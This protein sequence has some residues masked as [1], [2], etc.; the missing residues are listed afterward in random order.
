MSTTNPAFSFIIKPALKWHLNLS[1]KRRHSPVYKMLANQNTSKNFIAS[2]V[3][4]FASIYRTNRASHRAAVNLFV[5]LASIRSWG[6][7]H[8]CR[9]TGCCGGK[10]NVENSSTESK[11]TVGSKYPRHQSK[12]LI[13]NVA[14]IENMGRSSLSNNNRLTI[15]LRND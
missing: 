13:T 2:P 6:A 3:T 12:F 5:C 8:L 15:L 9:K 7:F 14:A 10:S 11:G 1:I 4:T